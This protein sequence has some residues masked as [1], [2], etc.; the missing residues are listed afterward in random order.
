MVWD[1]LY[2]VDEKLEPQRQMVR[3]GESGRVL[4]AAMRAWLPSLQDGDRLRRG[5]GSGKFREQ[6]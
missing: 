2:G 1:T 4:V 3:W 6:T 5:P